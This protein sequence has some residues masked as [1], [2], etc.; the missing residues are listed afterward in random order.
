MIP[1]RMLAALHLALV[2]ATAYGAGTPGCVPVGDGSEGPCDSDSRPLSGTGT[3][4]KAF[5]TVKRVDV[6]SGLIAVAHDEVKAL[7]WPAMTMV[8]QVS[9]PDMLRDIVVGHR[10][11]LTFV[12]D[13][14]QYV[15]TD[16][17]P[18]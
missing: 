1:Q 12:Q 8:F 6:S 16:M 11:E 2:A 10:Y 18:R 5:G 7:R 13:G 4:Y 14:N 17:R 15:V 9:R 3:S